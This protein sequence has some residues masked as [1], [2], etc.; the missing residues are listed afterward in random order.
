MDLSNSMSI[1]HREVQILL[2]GLDSL[3]SQLLFVLVVIYVEYVHKR[4]WTIS[5]SILCKILSG[6][7]ILLLL[8]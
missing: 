8:A 4:N 7:R 3:D 2:Y 5:L 1:V 6:G